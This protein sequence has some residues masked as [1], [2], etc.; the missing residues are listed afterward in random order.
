MD[1]ILKMGTK[2]KDPSVLVCNS[3]KSKCHPMA[4]CVMSFSPFGFTFKVTRL[5]CKDLFSTSYLPD[6]GIMIL[7][8]IES[9]RFILFYALNFIEV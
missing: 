3:A 1:S 8:K 5:F 6:T 2:G 4:S 7:A 9:L